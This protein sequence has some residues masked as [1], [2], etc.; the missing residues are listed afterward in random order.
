MHEES[1]DWFSLDTDEAGQEVDTS[2]DR[3]G[4]RFV[5]TLFHSYYDIF[6][7]TTLSIPLIS[8]Y[9]IHY[10]KRRKRKTY[11]L[12]N[13]TQPNPSQNFDLDITIFYFQEEMRRP[14]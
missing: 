14:A 9:Y 5:D 2:G 7:F 3:V 4:Y 8:I 10:R 6:F 13:K 1:G 11:I 12:N